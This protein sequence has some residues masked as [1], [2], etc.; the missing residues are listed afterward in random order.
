VF[1]IEAVI[2]H[3]AS[4][5]NFVACKRIDFGFAVSLIGGAQNGNRKSKLRVSHGM[6]QS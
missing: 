3:A 4:H 1:E 2:V 6:S 5:E